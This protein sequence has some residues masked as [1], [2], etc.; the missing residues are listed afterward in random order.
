MKLNQYVVDAFTD[1]VFRGNPAAVC[2]LSEWIPDMLMQNIAKENNLSE[3]AFTVKR[4]NIYELRWFTPGGEIDLC[5]HAT[6]G[7]AY[8]L[9]RFIEKDSGSISFQTKSGQLIVKKVNDLYEMD[10]PAYPLTEVP[11]TDEM[12]LAIGFRPSEA[13]LGR[14]LVCV[15]ADEQQ[16]L[17]AMP[18]EERLKELD[19]LLLQLTA[20]GTTYDC[21]TRSFAPKLNVL[22]DPVCG[23]GHCHV[24]PLWANKI[25]KRELI[26]FQASKRSGVLYCRIE[27]DRVILAGKAILYSKAEIYVP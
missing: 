11:V 27:N 17:Q 14:D 6:L 9:F 8:V 1:K 24:I 12:E 18:N 21:V 15:M 3:T 5:G 10:M 2:V 20:K 16:V 25:K 22:E 4:E 23:S 26:A 19:G 13:W 7:T